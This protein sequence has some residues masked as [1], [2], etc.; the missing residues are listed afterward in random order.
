[1]DVQ[2]MTA[3]V[4]SMIKEG[5]FEEKPFPEEGIVL[6]RTEHRS[7]HVPAS[8]N[9]FTLV[10]KDD[11]WKYFHWPFAG[12]VS[13]TNQRGY[14]RRYEVEGKPVSHD[15]VP[16]DRLAVWHESSWW[17]INGRYH[18]SEELTVYTKVYTKKPSSR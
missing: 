1:M 9:N 6:R 11:E 13:T 5:K 15:D 3:K 4:S 16:G 10:K 8:S 14:P 7:A 18:H 17:D 12:C 2:E